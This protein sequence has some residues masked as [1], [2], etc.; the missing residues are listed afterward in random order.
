MST[1]QHLALVLPEPDPATR[2]M[3]SVNLPA[4]LFVAFVHGAESVARDSLRRF[5]EGLRARYSKARESGD[6]QRAAIFHWLQENSLY[7]QDAITIVLEGDSGQK[8]LQPEQSNRVLALLRTEHDR[9]TADPL[10]GTTRAAQHLAAAPS[11]FTTESTDPLVYLLESV[12]LAHGVGEAPG[13]DSV[14]NQ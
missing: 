7:T 8:Q 1:N 3:S 4:L 10:V 14:C 5:D 9:K 6:E 12:R 13:Q 11:H 2:R